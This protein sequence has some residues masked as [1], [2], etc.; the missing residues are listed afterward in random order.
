MKSPGH[1]KQIYWAL[2]KP[3]D[4]NLRGK[5][6]KAYILKNKLPK[7]KVIHPQTYTEYLPNAEIFGFLAFGT[8]VRRS[9]QN[10][11]KQ[12]KFYVS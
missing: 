2:S 9:D 3:T 7:A 8:I 6:V 12:H 4:S 11:G 1:N 10:W 5:A